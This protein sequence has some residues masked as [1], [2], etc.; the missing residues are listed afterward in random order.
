MSGEMSFTSLPN[1]E[2]EEAEEA[3]RASKCMLEDFSV[4][5]V[6]RMLLQILV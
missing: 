6:R 3:Y 4:P 1:Q 2:R 5:D